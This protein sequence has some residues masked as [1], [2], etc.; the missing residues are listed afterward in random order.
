MKASRL[1]LLVGFVAVAFLAVGC[2]SKETVEEQRSAN[3]TKYI[4]Q[5]RQ[6]PYLVEVHDNDDRGPGVIEGRLT[7]KQGLSASFVISMG[8]SAA[9]I[10]EDYPD[11]LD[12]GALVG[13]DGLQYVWD[14]DTGRTLNGAEETALID[15]VLEAQDAGCQALFGKPCEI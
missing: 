6:L 13:G 2:G 1:L 11:A 5:L 14:N 8:P 9:E 10:L 15:M 3:A 12:A 4:E 7:N